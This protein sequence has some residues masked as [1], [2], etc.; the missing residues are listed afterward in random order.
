[1]FEIVN[2]L[3]TNLGWDGPFTYDTQTKTLAINETYYS[4][5]NKAMNSAFTT[6]K[7]NA[8]SKIDNLTYLSQSEKTSVKSLID[9]A[10]LYKDTYVANQDYSNKVLIGSDKNIQTIVQKW[11]DIN[12]EREKIKDYTATFGYPDKNIKPSTYNRD[13][14]TRDSISPNSNDVEA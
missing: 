12:T 6:A 3:L 5:I 4:K 7:S 1:K 2:N 14:I 13:S 11:T 9:Q 10:E 8:K